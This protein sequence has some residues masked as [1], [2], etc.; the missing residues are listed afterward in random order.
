MEMLMLG[1][2]VGTHQIVASPHSTPAASNVIGSVAEL[3]STWLQLDNHSL[4]LIEHES[5]RDSVRLRMPNSCVGTRVD[6][7]RR[8]WERCPKEGL[9][10]GGMLRGRGRR[11]DSIERTDGVPLIFY[12]EVT[13]SR[14]NNPLNE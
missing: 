12:T 3:T 2:A 7:L 6:T 1:R 4:Y 9:A 8:Q 10:F 14:R 11:Y 5:K 13:P